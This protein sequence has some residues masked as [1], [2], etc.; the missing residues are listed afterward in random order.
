MSNIP[1]ALDGDNPDDFYQ[2][3]EQMKSPAPV[4]AEDGADEE[5]HNDCNTKEDT[6]Q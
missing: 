4:G 2:I 3:C 5:T 1:R 6:V